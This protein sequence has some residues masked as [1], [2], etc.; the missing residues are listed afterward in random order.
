MIQYRN[1]TINDVNTIFNLTNANAQA[2]LMLPRSKYKI[3]N[4]I[5]SF[6]V[7][8]DDE[9]HEV[10][11]CAALSP[12]WTDMAEIMALTVAD[13]YQKKRIGQTIVEYLLVQ[14]KVMGFP[15][16]ISLTYQ[17]DFFKKLGFTITDKDQ[18]PRKMW[19]ECLECPKL[20]NCD[21]TAM[22]IDI[23]LTV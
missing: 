12:L 23:D 22:Y 18:F 8:F 16:V 5:Q 15:K 20:E 1:A 10:V 4:M 11:G 6:Y 3:I 21:E 2:G 9:T 19:R 14:A 7:A 13:D 17:V